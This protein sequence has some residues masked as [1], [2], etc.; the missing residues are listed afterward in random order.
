M[1]T[2]KQE[3][4]AALQDIRALIEKLQKGVVAIEKVLVTEYPER[5][6]SEAFNEA[7]AELD[8]VADEPNIATAYALPDGRTLVFGWGE[9]DEADGTKRFVT[10]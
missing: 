9:W 7:Q 8:E 3:L 1:R 5:Q 4:E 2:H 10:G 6:H